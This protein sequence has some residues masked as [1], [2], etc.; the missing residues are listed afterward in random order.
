MKD[1]GALPWI[2]LIGLV[3]PAV[4][5]LASWRWPPKTTPY[6]FAPTPYNRGHVGQKPPDWYVLLEIAAFLCF[7]VA[8]APM[9]LFG[10]FIIAG[11]VFGA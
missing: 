6:R 8:G 4:F 11:V 2:V 3:F 7:L 1:P 9:L 5:A 10:V